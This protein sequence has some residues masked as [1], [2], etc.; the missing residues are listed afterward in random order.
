MFREGEIPANKR[1]VGNMVDIDH[2]LLYKLLILTI[3]ISI[4]LLLI[5][6]KSFLESQSTFTKA[7]RLSINQWDESSHKTIYRTRLSL[8]I[9]LF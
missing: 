8:P 2:Y 4:M 9:Q 6:I 7:A 5:I 3:M 1:V